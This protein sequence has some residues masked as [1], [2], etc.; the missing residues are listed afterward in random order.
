MSLF[1]SSCRRPPLGPV[2][3]PT[4]SVSRGTMGRRG[5]ST[6]VR[7]ENTWLGSVLDNSLLQADLE[8]RET[9]HYYTSHHRHYICKFHNYC[10][11]DHSNQLCMVRHNTKSDQASA[12]LDLTFNNVDLTNVR[13]QIVIHVIGA[14]LV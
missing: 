6:A 5:M 2:Q 11:S 9:S 7:P 4:T 13:C 1:S 14:A 12:K 8:W 3:A 10:M